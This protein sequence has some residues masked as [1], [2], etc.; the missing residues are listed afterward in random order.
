MKGQLKGQIRGQ[1][2]YQLKGQPSYQLRD[3]PKVRPPAAS[4]FGGA[5]HG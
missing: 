5:Q 2:S 1:P 4:A 3:Q